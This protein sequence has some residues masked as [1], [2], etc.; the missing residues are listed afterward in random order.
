MKKLLSIAAISAVTIL[1]GTG[2]SSSS[3]VL[4]SNAAENSAIYKSEVSKGSLHV[5]EHNTQKVM[6]SVKASGEKAGWK[7][8]SFKI[9]EFIAEKAS[10]GKTVSTNVKFHNEY[11]T[12]SREN[13]SESD[14]SEL[15]GAIEEGLSKDSKTH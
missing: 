1:L 2:C 13:A 9:N 12:F 15:M 4:P 10:G 7:M 5:K 6:H 3:K 11:I 14:V 8:T